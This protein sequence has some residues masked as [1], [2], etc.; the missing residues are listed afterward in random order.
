MDE[1]KKYVTELRQYFGDTVES[2]EED[3]AQ[4]FFKLLTEFA[5]QCT[6][7]AKELDEWAELVSL[8]STFSS[9]LTLSFSELL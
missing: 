9:F 3:S 8:V 6:G 1:V 4:A 5:I 2:K 7:A